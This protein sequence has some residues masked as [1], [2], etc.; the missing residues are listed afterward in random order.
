MSQR[1]DAINIIEKASGLKGLI[2]RPL[3]AKLLPPTIPEKE[4]LIDRERLL[5]I[6]G[7]KRDQQIALAGHFGI[8]FPSPAGGCRLT[9]P[10]FA[11]RLKEA[12]DH[13]EDGTVDMHLLR[14]GRH[15]R[16]N[17]GAKVIVGR[18]ESENE[19]ISNLAQEGDRLLE[20]IEFGSPVTLLKGA[21]DEKDISVAAS[22]CAR[23]SDCD[24]EE[25]VK[26]SVEGISPICVK[27]MDDGQLSEFRI[28]S[29]GRSGSRKIDER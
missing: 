11:V 2:L 12:F 9:D 5:A 4:G 23:Y 21:K 25:M 29:H 20:V 13:D 14:Y 26:V 6:F 7:R 16:L 3:S 18:N 22:I 15:F 8:S 28:G 27:P 24:R 1:R 19:Q 10:N 17:T